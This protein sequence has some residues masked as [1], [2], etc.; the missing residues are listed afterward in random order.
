MA[1][2]DFKELFQTAREQ[3]RLGNFRAAEQLLAQLLMQND[4]YPE[5]YH[6]LATIYYDQGKFNKAIKTFRR[7]LEVD[8]TFTDA[9]VGLSV[10]LND[11]GR[12]DEGKQVFHQ[13]QMAL[14]QRKSAQPDNYMNEKLALKHD[15]LGEMYFQ[16]KQFTQAMEQYMKALELTSRKPEIKMKIVE[17]LLQIGDRG[18][19]Q[20]ELESLLLEHSN[21]T[22]ARLKLGLIYYQARNVVRALEQWQTVLAKEPSNPL[23]LRYVQMARGSGADPGTGHGSSMLT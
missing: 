13:A 23:A 1:S 17:C 12:Y 2:A 19:A 8:P 20:R 22:A 3:F 4:S 5:I 7:A 11:L 21:F 6:M 16:H 9:A 18:R 15:E 14:K 10:V